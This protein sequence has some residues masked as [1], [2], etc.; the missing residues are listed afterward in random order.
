MVGGSFHPAGAQT[1]QVR[2][3]AHT[4]G[5]ASAPFGAI[6]GMLGVAPDTVLITDPVSKAVYRWDLASGGVSRFARE[7]RGPG[8][9][10][11]PVVLA[12]RPGGGVALYDI[13]R[14]GVLLYGSDH[15]FERLVRLK[16]GIISNPKGLAVL[17]DSSFVVSGGRLRDPRHLHRYSPAGDWIESYGAPSSAIVTDNAKVQSAG[18]PVRALDKGFLFSSGAPLRIQRFPSNDLQRPST[19]GEDLRLLPALTEDALHGPPKPRLHGARPFLWWYDRSTGVFALP[20]GRILNVV[21]RYYRGD[22]VWDLYGADGTRLARQVVPRAYYAWDLLPSGQ[23]LASY[24]DPDTD[25][26]IATVLTVV[27]R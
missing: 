27:L 25:E 22:S 10:Q 17:A 9:V 19:L 26:H 21:T 14:S 5:S 12:R 3:T 15:T 1:I 18:G 16:G 20:D 4:R 7:G 6:G 13:G 8:E 24:R 2:E 11:T 23:L